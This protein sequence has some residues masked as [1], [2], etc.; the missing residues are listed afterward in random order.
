MQ[1]SKQLITFNDNKLVLSSKLELE[2]TKIITVIGRARLGKS[3][4]LN[5][6]YS[7]L[8]GTEQETFKS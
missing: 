7:Y 6:I 2:K 3:S 1:Q 5:I 4:L 8:T